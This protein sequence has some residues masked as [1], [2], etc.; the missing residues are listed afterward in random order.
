M[1]VQNSGVGLFF[2]ILRVNLI[3]IPQGPPI[4]NGF[5]T[6]LTKMAK[7]LIFEYKSHHRHYRYLNKWGWPFNK[8]NCPTNPNGRELPKN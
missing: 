7:Q 6:L 5:P 1:V 8:V 4:L 3:S 2:D